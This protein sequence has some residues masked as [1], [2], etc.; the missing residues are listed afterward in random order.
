MRAFIGPWATP[1]LESSGPVLQSL[2]AGA[3]QTSFASILSA[4]KIQRVKKARERAR[5]SDRKCRLQDSRNPLAL[6]RLRTFFFATAHEFI[7][8]EVIVR[9][10]IERPWSNRRQKR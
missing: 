3:G 9:G 2:L 8:S 5:A 6:A 4:G 10:Q 7:L 1:E